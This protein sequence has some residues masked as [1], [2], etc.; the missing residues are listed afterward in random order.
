MS[1]I[2]SAPNALNLWYTSN[3][4]LDTFDRHELRLPQSEIELNKAVLILEYGSLLGC[5]TVW[6]LGT[7]E[8]I[9]VNGET[10]DTLITRDTEFANVSELNLL[11]D[12]ALAD[13]LNLGK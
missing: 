4:L 3:K 7:T 6:G 5:F 2:C 13:F 11:L 8:W 1:S 10:G 12:S 9:V